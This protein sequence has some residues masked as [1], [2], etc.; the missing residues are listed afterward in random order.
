M[1]SYN[2]YITLSRSELAHGSSP[3]S[4]S[5]RKEQFQSLL[6]INEQLQLEELYEAYIPLAEILHMRVVAAEQFKQSMSQYFTHQHK[7]VPYI[8]G[9]AGS[10]AAGKS[11]TARLLQALLSQY[12]EHPRIDIVTTDGFLLPNQ[13][14]QQRGIMNKKGFPQSYNTKQLLRFLT[15]VKSGEP[16]VKAPV[17]SHV[18]YDIVAD[19]HITINSPDIL[20]IEGINVLQVNMDA[21]VFVSDFFDC[22]LYVDASVDHL[23][24]WYIERFKMLRQTAFHD[25]HSYFK[26]Y[27]EISEEDA[28]ALAHEVWNNVNLVNLIDNILPTRN[29][30]Q[31]IVQKGEGHRIE[32]LFIRK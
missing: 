18:T 16:E 15:D 13:E 3:S 27:T 1:T 30:A 2:P 4:H 23:E 29:R 17:Y 6:G 11:T 10:V 7:P 24:K 22:S 32:K 12:S 28:V 21:P 31:I 14:L 25:S 9:I 19:Q 5:L 26:R 20:I 8:I